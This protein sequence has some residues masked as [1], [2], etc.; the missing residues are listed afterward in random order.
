[1]QEYKD[2]DKKKAA[3]LKIAAALGPDITADDVAKKF[4]R[5]RIQ[6]NRGRAKLTATPKS[7]SSA[8]D[9]KKSKV[10]W[11]HFESLN[12]LKD[13]CTLK[14]TRSNFLASS[15]ASQ[16]TSPSAELKYWQSL[17]LTSLAVRRVLQTDCL[18][19]GTS[20]LGS[21]SFLQDSSEMVPVVLSSW[22]KLPGGVDGPCSRFT[23]KEVM[24]CN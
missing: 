14:S 7:G 3:L 21:P 1:M 17:F 6:Y 12:Y 4:A 8:D 22:S 11:V 16:G 5:L 24:Q 23:S 20:P 13:F 18:S 15:S 19:M 10:T 2:R 9:A